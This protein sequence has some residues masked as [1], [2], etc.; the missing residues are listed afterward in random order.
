MRRF[1]NIAKV[2]LVMQPQQ[3]E[4]LGRTVAS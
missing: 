4:A 1:M 3:L 2:A